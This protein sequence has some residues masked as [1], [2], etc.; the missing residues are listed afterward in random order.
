MKQD[1]HQRAAVKNAGVFTDFPLYSLV[2]M[3]DVI[4]I[5]LGCFFQTS[6]MLSKA[7]NSLEK[8]PPPS[9]LRIWICTADS[10]LAPYRYDRLDFP[11]SDLHLP[12]LRIFMG[13]SGVAGFF[14][15]AMVCLLHVG[16]GCLI[17]L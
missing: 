9:L 17:E 6:I 13:T 5:S 12:V 3:M 15:C 2:K 1:I 11:D 4:G 8:N 10:G 14:A 16:I 7:I